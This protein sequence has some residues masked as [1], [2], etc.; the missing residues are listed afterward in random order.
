M[1]GKQGLAV[2]SSI[3]RLPR[4]APKLL[5]LK[6]M[7]SSVVPP[8]LLKS[9][10]MEQIRTG[11]RRVMSDLLKGQP[12]DEAAVLAWP[13]VCGAEVA[14]RTRA[15]SFNDGQLIVE[16]PDANW[17]SQLSAFL[18]RYLSGLSDLVGPVVKEIRFTIGNL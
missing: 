5:E 8:V 3:K 1:A 18:P 15:V 6:S 10:T 4:I 16:V 11:L 7:L 12:P 17:R 9:N 2:L 14:A 13:V